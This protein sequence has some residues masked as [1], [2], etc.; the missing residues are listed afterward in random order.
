MGGDKTQAPIERFFNKQ[1]IS[2][3]R[4]KKLTSLVK[5]LRDGVIDKHLKEFKNMAFG[6]NLE[7]QIKERLDTLC[8]LLYQNASNCLFHV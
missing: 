4:F 7:L 2:N 3:D 8:M 1:D 5:K 6:Q